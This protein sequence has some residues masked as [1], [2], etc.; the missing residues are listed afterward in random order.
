MLSTL[1]LT[2]QKTAGR[3]ASSMRSQQVVSMSSLREVLAAQIPKKQE[4]LKALKKEYGHLSLGE[5]TV[6]QA[7]GGGRD[8]QSLYYETSLLDAQEVGSSIHKTPYLYLTHIVLGWNI[9]ILMNYVLRLDVFSHVG[10]SVSWLQYSRAPEEAHDFHRNCR[11]WRA[12]SRGADM[13]LAHFRVTH[14][15]PDQVDH[16]GPMYLQYPFFLF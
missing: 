16:S 10:N 13:A 12:N 5:V 9:P 6:D 11:R 7:I 1:R 14:C 8:V 3:L 4:E 2:A 15:R